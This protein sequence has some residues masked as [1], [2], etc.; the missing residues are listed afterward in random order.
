MN[1][2]MKVGIAL[3]IV[4]AVIIVAVA[5]FLIGMNV[6]LVNL[7]TAH[8]NLVRALMPPQ[9]QQQAMPQQ[10]PM[11]PRPVAQPAPE[12]APVAPTK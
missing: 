1:K 5:L 12:Q 9:Q 7:E 11:R 4:I 3:G 10:A 2:D 6:R 8:N